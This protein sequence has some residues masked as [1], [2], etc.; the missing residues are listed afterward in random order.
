M[1]RE[2]R[3]EKPD[4]GLLPKS[5]LLAVAYV[6]VAVKL[7]FGLNDDMEEWVYAVMVMMMMIWLDNWY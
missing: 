6:I 7:V 3:L 1:R 2:P 5:E 4:R